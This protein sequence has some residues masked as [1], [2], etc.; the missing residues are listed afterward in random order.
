M[1]TADISSVAANQS[2]VKIRFSYNDPP[3]DFPEPNYGYYYLGVDDG[4]VYENP[5]ANNLAVLQVMN[6]DVL[7]L[8]EFKNYPLEQSDNIL[9]GA[10]YANY[11]SLLQTGVEITWDILSGVDIIHTS[12]ESLGDVPTSREDATGTIVQNIDTAWFETGFTIEELG[13]YTIRAT[14]TGNEEEEMPENAI[15][16]REITVT[17]DVMSHDDV[18]LLNGSL[19]PRDGDDGAGFLFEEVG[20]GTLFF[21]VNP[22]SQAYGVQAVFAELTTPGTLAAIEFYEVPDTDDGINSGGDN[23]PSDVPLDENEFEVTEDI[24]GQSVFIPFLEPV[25]LE[26]GKIYMAVIRQ[27]EGDE[28]LYVQG[29]NDTDTDNSS[30]LREKGG[31]GDYVWFS[32]PIELAVRLGFSETVSINDISKLDI[33]LT[34]APNPFDNFTN[35]SYSLEESEKVSFK[36]FDVQG[37]LVLENN[38]GNQ[39][40]GPHNIK[41]DGNDLESGIY[42]LNIL[43]GNSNLT[44]VLVISK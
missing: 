2:N 27:F 43:V 37:R 18:N 8:Y 24:M 16:E 14:L 11:G 15:L 41:I 42:Y 44:E 1:V 33:G 17:P 21:V 28:A 29:T 19:G 26:V 7:N 13:T 31:G 12:V 20:F 6:G 23:M 5:Y 38:F 40:S 10:V 25:D 36:M 4:A 30:F 39:S 9:V 35:V 32:R 22:G 34:V 3:S